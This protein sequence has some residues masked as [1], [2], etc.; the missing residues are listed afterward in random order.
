MARSSTG[1]RAAPAAMGVHTEVQALN[2][3]T[4]SGRS[5]ANR[6]AD[7][8]FA[9]IMELDAAGGWHVVR[10]SPQG[11]VEGLDVPAMK[12]LQQFFGDESDWPG[13]LPVPLAR[14][15]LE[16]RD[17]G[18]SLSLARRW[19]RFALVR[20]GLMLTAHFVPD[21]E[22]GYL[23]LRTEPAGAAAGAPDLALT[24]LPLTNREQEIVTLV[25]AGKSN[26]E[27][28]ILLLISA[29]TVQKHLEN[30][31]RKLGVESRMALVARVV[32]KPAARLP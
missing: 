7:V 27:I 21:G 32:A 9:R 15:V 25:A 2:T 20:F 10:L 11:A 23:V 5:N 12:V 8:N 18:M 14:T 31:F 1:E 6:A 13:G 26:V 19:R 24:T 30:I 4:A 16:S 22:A 3:G 17:W 29:R 28:G